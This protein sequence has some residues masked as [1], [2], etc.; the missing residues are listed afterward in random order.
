MRRELIR[1]YS[2]LFTAG[3]T[4][5]I[6]RNPG[7]YNISGETALFSKIQQIANVHNEIAPGVFT[8]SRASAHSLNLSMNPARNQSFQLSGSAKLVVL[9]SV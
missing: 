9:S 3:G 7:D 4:E 6:F 1:V 5:I 2:K 8:G